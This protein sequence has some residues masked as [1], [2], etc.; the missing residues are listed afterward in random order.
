MAGRAAHSGYPRQN[1]EKSPGFYLRKFTKL[2]SA[3]SFSVTSG[4]VSSIFAV[5]E[6]KGDCAKE[7]AH[8]PCRLPPAKRNWDAGGHWAAIEEVRVYAMQNRI[9]IGIVIVDERVW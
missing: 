3:G 5:E 2:Y 4:G 7:P 1:R 8:E 6:S 9:F